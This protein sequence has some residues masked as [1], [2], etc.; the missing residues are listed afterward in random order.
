MAERPLLRS[1][2]R[3]WS[4]IKGQLIGSIRVYRDE[5]CLDF[6]ILHAGFLSWIDVDHVMVVVLFFDWLETN[7]GHYSE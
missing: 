3:C 2:G 4:R 6:T 7:Q 1:G 5:V